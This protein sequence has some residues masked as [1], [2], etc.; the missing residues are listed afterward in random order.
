M[1]TA[2]NAFEDNQAASMFSRESTPILLMK[3]WWVH[4]IAH[5]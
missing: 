4:R 2:F 1:T 5:E 3:T